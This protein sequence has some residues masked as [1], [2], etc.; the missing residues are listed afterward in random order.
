MTR[1]MIDA[2]IWANEHFFML[3]PMARLLQIGIINMA[4]DQGRMK[5]H[6]AYLRSQIFPYD[7]VMIDDVESWLGMIAANSTLMLYEVDGKAYLQL[8]NW[9]Q[10]QSPAFASPS[11]YPRPEGW[12]DRVRY[13]GKSRIIYTCN[14]S[15]SSGELLPDTCDQDGNPLPNDGEPGAQ[16]HG[17]PHGEPGTPLIEYKYKYKYKKEKGNA[18]LSFGATSGAAPRESV[19]AAEYTNR[20]K[21]LG[22]D[23]RQFR[24]NVDALLEIV[25]KRALV[26]ANPD[27]RDTTFIL[28][29]A[30]EAVLSLAPLGYGTP[31]MLKGLGDSW[32]ATNQWRHAP[33]TFRQLKEHASAVASGVQPKAQQATNG[34]AGLSSD[35][36]EYEGLT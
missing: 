17:E 1:R 28:N 21:A 11:Q 20:A 36:P 31:D 8:L 14:W 30:K 16:P 24:R 4:D 26:D 25:G 9:W 23:A 35:I 15:T 18:P 29:D 19:A 5:A 2:G 33:P 22:L 32:L 10:Y 7:D 12:Q 27:D 6:P 3:P 13:T 34:W